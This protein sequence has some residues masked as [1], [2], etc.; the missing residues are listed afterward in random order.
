MRNLISHH[1][2]AVEPIFRTSELFSASLGVSIVEMTGSRL[3]YLK[4]GLGALKLLL[5]IADDYL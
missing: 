5:I 1:I 3:S 4:Y 2:C